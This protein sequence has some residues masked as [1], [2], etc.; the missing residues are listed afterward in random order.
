MNGGVFKEPNLKMRTAGRPSWRM[1]PSF[2]PTATRNLTVAAVRH[3]PMCV[4]PRKTAMPTCVPTDREKQTACPNASF[5]TSS[6][7][8]S[9]GCSASLHAAC[10]RVCAW[11]WPAR[12]KSRLQWAIPIYPLTCPRDRLSPV[13]RVPCIP[14]HQDVAVRCVRMVSTR[15]GVCP[16][17]W[18]ITSLSKRQLEN[19]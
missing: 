3:T 4:W 11:R 10:L 12:S 7:R 6:T 9:G 13:C 5:T 16:A 17:R 8:A 1:A 15:P 2:A 19:A 18:H 14:I